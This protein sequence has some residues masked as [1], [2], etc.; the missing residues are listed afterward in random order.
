[1]VADLAKSRLST[2]ADDLN[3]RPFNVAL[4]A[5]ENV[6]ITESVGQA[7]VA[8][9]RKSGELLRRFGA[10][11]GIERPTGIA[12]DRQRHLVY[13]TDSSVQRSQNHRVMVYDEEGKFLRQIGGGPGR[14]PRGSGDGQ[15][16]FPTYLAVRSDGRLFVA[17]TMNFRIQSFD[18]S[19]AFV[20][21]FGEAGDSPGAFYR[22]KGLAFDGFDN[23]YVADGEHSAV[24]IFNGDGQFLMFFGGFQPSLLEYFDVPGGVAIHRPTN[25][26]Y[27]GNEYNARV[28]VYELVNTTAEDSRPR[29]Q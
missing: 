23:L 15:F 25:H 18:P 20:S 12:I 11:E 27:V 21:K 14:S 17:D 24:Q 5:A 28:N 6:Y 2:F 16:H 7:G 13:V 26:I 3:G 9:F 19:G 1:M 22:I 10:V 8:V 4:D 29:K